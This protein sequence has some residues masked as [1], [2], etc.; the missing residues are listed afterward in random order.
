MQCS[1]TKVMHSG[2]TLVW[3]HRNVAEGT[4]WATKDPKACGW[5][6]LSTASLMCQRTQDV[7][8]YV[9]W[10]SLPRR[11]SVSFTW[12]FP[13]WPGFS[14]LFTKLHFTTKFKTRL[15]FKTLQLQNVLNFIQL[16]LF[17]TPIV[18]CFP[19]E[20]KS[21]NFAPMGKNRHTNLLYL[22]SQLLPGTINMKGFKTF[23]N[24]AWQLSY[25][26]SVW[27]GE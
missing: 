14:I 12:V 8:H 1:C 2:N 5:R 16:L 3:L 24:L 7:S 15:L 27:C 26:W 18:P 11:C 13:L 10:A 25:L 17:L 22:S 9:L 20:N 23:D 6:E 21:P 4:Q 19:N